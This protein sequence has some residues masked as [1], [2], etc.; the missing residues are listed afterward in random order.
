[1]QY[2]RGATQKKYLRDLLAPQVKR[3]LQ[4]SD[5]DLRC[6]PI[7]VRGS[8][9]SLAPLANALVLQIYKAEIT[10]EE[11]VTGVPSS[12]PK[13]PDYLA[14]IRDPRAGPIF[15]RRTSS[16]PYS[17]THFANDPACRPPRSPR[18]DRRIPRRYARIDSAYALWCT[19]RRSR[20]LQRATPE[21]SRRRGAEHPSPSLPFG[22]LPVHPARRDVRAS[23]AQ[24]FDSV[25]ICGL[26]VRPRR[27]ALSKASSR[28]RSARTW[29][30]SASSS[31]RSRSAASSMRSSAT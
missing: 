17:R 18:N 15:V 30:K 4:R 6:D 20:G 25:L 8:I 27:S 5:L 22:L 9:A 21:V 13:E 10:R 26:A 31:T 16:G 23:L 11:T 19:L 29:V 12:R 3:I 28:R 1:M 14:A 24:L 2:G 7:V